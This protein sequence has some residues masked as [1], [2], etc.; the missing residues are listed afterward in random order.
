MKEL[1][2]SRIGTEFPSVQ[3]RVDAHDGEI[4]RAG[5]QFQMRTTA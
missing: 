5:S 3:A 2:R 4:H 1:D